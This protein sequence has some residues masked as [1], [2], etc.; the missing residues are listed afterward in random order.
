MKA[1]RYENNPID[2]L[3]QPKYNSFIDS[4][5]NHDFRYGWNILNKSPSLPK[6]RESGAKR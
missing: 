6:L 3:S 1:Q 5:N 2:N 4:R